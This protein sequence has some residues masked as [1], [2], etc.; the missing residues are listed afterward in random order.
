MLLVICLLSFF[1][2]DNASESSSSAVSYSSHGGDSVT[3]SAGPT[4]ASSSSRRSSMDFPFFSSYASTATR[5]GVFFLFFSFLF[6]SLQALSFVPN[7]LILCTEY[8]LTC[9]MVCRVG[10]SFHFF[11]SSF[12]SPLQAPSCIGGYV[13]ACICEALPQRPHALY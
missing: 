4:S 11:I 12:F 8:E 9:F 3:A 5:L 7:D 6:F 1:L 10:H 13:L 2:T